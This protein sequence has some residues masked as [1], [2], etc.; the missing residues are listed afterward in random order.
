MQHAPQSPSPAV[1]PALRWLLAAAILANLVVLWSV[2][3]LPMANLGLHV[4]AMDLATRYNDVQTGY[5]AW[6]VLPHPL[7]PGTLPL[8]CARLLPFLN[9]WTVARLLLSAYVI[10]L[11]LSMMALARAMGRSPWLA[12]FAAP[13]TWN[14][15]VNAGVLNFLIAL[16]LL[17]WSLAMARTMAISGGARRGGLLTV[18]LILLY[19]CH[20]V[21]FGVGI[22]SV[23]FL[24]VWYRRDLWSL[25]R[26]WV[27]LPAVP[28]L[29]QLSFRKLVAAQNAAA[30]HLN[31]PPVP[32]HTERLPTRMLLERLYDWTLLFFTDHVDYAVAG[33]LLM[34]WPILLLIGTYD[35][36]TTN[37]GLLDAKSFERRMF[38]RRQWTWARAR[39]MWADGTLFTSAFDRRRLRW[40]TVQA[41]LTEHGLEALTVLWALLYLL[42][43]TQYRGV[44]VVAEL[45]PLPTLLLLA[46][47]PRLHFTGWRIWLAVPLFAVALAYAWQV[48][49][50]FQ[51]FS[52][53]EVAGLPAQLADLPT[54]AR[55]AYVEWARESA[56]TYK[57]PLRHLPTGVVA[58]Q[59]GG[60]TDDNPA[61][62][63]QAIVHFR[64]GLGSVKLQSDFWLDPALMEVDFVLL[65]SG[66]A[67]EAAL[68]SARVEH[69]WHG[70]AWWLFRVQHSAR[71]RM[72]LVTVGGTGGLAAY[73]DCPRGAVLQG[74]IAQPGAQAV[75]SLVPLCL[76]LRTAKPA[77]TPPEAGSRLGTA[78]D[79]AAESQLLCPPGQYV[80]SLTGRADVYVNAIQVQCSPAPWP[81]AQFTLTPTRVI[82]GAGG[83]DFDVHCPDG[84][85]G[86]GL[87][88]RFGDV[89]DQIGLACAELTTW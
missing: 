56:V 16:P 12:L 43:P 88:G 4:Q 2:Q 68:Q 11:P 49:A 24:F 32:T 64:K 35:V 5:R 46:L 74:L 30:L 26:L 60:L 87:Q 75:Q 73:G 28:L 7:D 42:L 18:A 6:F 27:V 20:L 61:T 33:A 45:L 36:A 37:R 22:A 80:V 85:V 81:D 48:H 47:W 50:E 71:E 13:M 63:P 69:V 57:N 15:L 84:M 52:N 14:A 66:T 77:H 10:G 23:V 19:F 3:W 72:K 53:S 39:R 25:S 65:R 59:H 44:P 62:Q 58:S 86:V 21:S 79:G 17:F 51:A 78:P 40:V 31:A 8:W 82:G 70:S 34:L 55:F 54:G 76:D 41:W 1:P 83:K 9:P 38:G 89:T 29:L 67:P